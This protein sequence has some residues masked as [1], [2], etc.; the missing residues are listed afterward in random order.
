M[1]RVKRRDSQSMCRHHDKYVPLED[2][3]CVDVAEALAIV[4]V[5]CCDDTTG[6]AACTARERKSTRRKA[7]RRAMAC[8]RRRCREQGLLPFERGAV[9]LNYSDLAWRSSV[10]ALST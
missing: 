3:A 5:V 4:E 10:D 6:S 9:L 1:N 7:S 8:R 2:R